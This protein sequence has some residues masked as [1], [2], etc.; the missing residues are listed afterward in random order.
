MIN[1]LAICMH[2]QVIHYHLPI[3]LLDFID[4]KF[5]T[6]CQKVIMS[7]MQ[8]IQIAEDDF[9]R[10]QNLKFLAGENNFM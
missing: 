4:N 7:W 1:F 8:L 5:G 2:L 10:Y 3:K 9:R 6:I